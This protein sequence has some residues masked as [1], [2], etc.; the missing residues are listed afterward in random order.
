MSSVALAASDH[1]D[2]LRFRVE[3]RLDRR[4]PRTRPPVR[5]QI[6]IDRFRPFQSLLPSSTSSTVARWTTSSA[7]SLTLPSMDPDSCAQPGPG[8]V[9][10]T[11]SGH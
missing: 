11:K 3:G 1:F 4:G 9:T 10:N 2:K 5:L 7:E 6:G 8:T